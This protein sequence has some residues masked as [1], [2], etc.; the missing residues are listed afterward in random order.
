MFASPPSCTATPTGFAVLTGEGVPIRMPGRRDDL[1]PA[2]ITAAQL[3]ELYVEEDLTISEVARRLGCSDTRV[4]AALER[5]QMPRHPDRHRHHR[6]P[7]VDIDAEILTRLYVDE[8]L[9]DIA[10]A[11]RYHVPPVRIRRRRSGLGIRR[12]PATPPH[13]EPPPPPPAKQLKQLYL[14]DKL[15]LVVIARRYHTSTP[16][17]RRWLTEGGIPVRPRTSR[18]DRQQ[19]DPL[20]LRD[21]YEHQR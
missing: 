3:Q 14:F 6:V 5:F 19:L 4:G 16:V 17:V 13:R 1:R 7:A 8:K 10:I 2:P 20:M 12:P 21:R 18:S 15:P 11:D 9:D